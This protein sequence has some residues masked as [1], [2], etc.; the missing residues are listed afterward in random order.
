MRIKIS[1]IATLLLGQASI[2]A[3]DSAADIKISAA[4]HAQSTAA[5]ETNAQQLAL[6]HFEK[7]VNNNCHRLHPSLLAAGLATHNITL[8]TTTCLEAFT[9]DSRPCQHMIYQAMENFRQH[10]AR[11]RLSGAPPLYSSLAYDTLSL[12][13][14]LRFAT[15]IID[16]ALNQTFPQD[17]V[18]LIAGYVPRETFDVTINDLTNHPI[19]QDAS[20]HACTYDLTTGQLTIHSTLYHCKRYTTQGH[21]EYYQSDYPIGPYTMAKQK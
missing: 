10:H 21:T 16:A 2:F 14:N 17:L 8:N 5:H 3:S 13:Y 9:F 12:R 20:E 19:T 11:R 18:S 6:S 1:L 15:P 7:W 4:M